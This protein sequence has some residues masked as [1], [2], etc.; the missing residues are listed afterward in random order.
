MNWFIITIVVIF[1]IAIVVFTIIRNHKDEN[2][3]EENI[4]N[5]YLK[6]KDEKDEFDDDVL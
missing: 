6:L 4:K 2:N 3:F 5:D 1:G